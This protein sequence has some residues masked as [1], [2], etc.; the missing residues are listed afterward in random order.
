MVKAV[1][2][3]S[4]GLDSCLAAKILQ[5][6]IDLYGV[7]FISPFFEQDLTKLAKQ[8]NLP[9]KTIELKEDYI[10]MLRKP[11]HGY[12]KNINPCIDCK[13]FML[14]KAKEYAKQINAKF[15]VTGEVLNERPMSQHKKAL[16]LIEK[17]ANLKN[18]I[19]RPLSAKVLPKTIAEKYVK[20][21]KLLAIQGRSRKPQLE[22][23]K[24]YKLKGYSTP[25]GGCLLTQEQYARKVKDLFKNKKIITIDDCKL[26][27]LG[28]H[29]R[30]KNSKIIVGRNEQE[31]KQ[32]SKFKGIL[33]EPLDVPGPTTLLQG[34]DIKIAAALTARY[35][36]S[37][38]KTK[39][40]YNNKIISAAPLKD[41]EI[42][43]LRI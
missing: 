1:L 9:L 26:L 2:L 41:K 42:E 22:L 28:R 37:K 19:L 16:M 40:K 27:K 11:K 4:G 7:H 8:I 12:G 23:A 14:K 31:N 18:Q 3:F 32:I 43:K 21:E 5:K 6:Q 24:K 34:K 17:E 36:D 13:I 30:Y 33:L 25:A 29:F 39:I 20:K 15:I 38:G 10:E 35:S